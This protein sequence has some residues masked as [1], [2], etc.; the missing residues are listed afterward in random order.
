[1]AAPVAATLLPALLLVPLVVG[2]GI[3]LFCDPVTQSFP[4][5]ALYARAVGA[6]QLPLFNPYQLGGASFVGNVQA[7]VLYPPH[8]VVALARGP[9]DRSFGLLL[10]LHLAWA[11]L[12]TERL[13][14]RLGMEP[15]GAVVAALA[16]ALGG[17][18][19]GKLAL[20]PVLLTAA[21]A[22][23]VMLGVEGTLAGRSRGLGLTA[24]L[25]LLLTAGH[26]QTALAV[27][28]FATVY[29]AARLIPLRS[30]SGPAGL[31]GP[32]TVVATIL[33]LAYLAGAFTVA[34]F[35]APWFAPTRVFF[36]AVALAGVALVA[37]AR[38]GVPCEL[39]WGPLAPVARMGGALLLGSC[40]AAA[41][42]LP[43]VEHLAQSRPPR[44]PDRIERFDAIADRPALAAD[45]ILGH[46]LDAEASL[47]VGPVPALLAL[48]WL[49][50][51]GSRRR[52]PGTAYALS[53][54]VWFLIACG[55]MALRPVLLQLPLFR[56][57][58]GLTRYLVGPALSLSLLA[59]LAVGL[60]PRRARVGAAAVVLVAATI[61]P[62]AHG[63]R[64]FLVAA[65][66]ASIYPAAAPP[67]ELVRAELV[68]FFSVD[69]TP[70]LLG[71]DFR[72]ADLA[73]LLVPNL[74]TLYRLE[75]LQ[76]YDPV[77]G[78]AVTRLLAAL[79]G[80]GVAPLR[81]DYHFAL[82]RRGT[83]RLLAL[84]GVGYALVHPG[85]ADPPLG[86]ERVRALQGVDLYAL[87]GALPRAFVAPRLVIEPDPDRALELLATTLDPA[88]D[89][90]IPHTLAVAAYGSV[91]VRRPRDGR[92]VIEARD[93]TFGGL[94]VV[95]ELFD[96]AW[97]AW[98]DGRRVDPI[99]TDGV[100]VG[101]PCPSAT[102]RVELA[103]LPRGVLVGLFVA[104]LGLLT[105]CTCVAVR[106]PWP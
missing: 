84:L 70:V 18:M 4:Y 73:P 53:G 101:V 33:A 47:H 75:D 5:H 2:G 41:T 103:Y 100:L 80:A 65:T 92:L 89:A 51:R 39:A 87:R 98:V 32:V 102:R 12:G 58:G 17:Y 43:V 72:R 6:G 68:R 19:V 76:G 28:G 93:R 40:L 62:L 74:G 24:A 22:P 14:R 16:F 105:C 66:A 26:P 11:G 78:R 88:V 96:R 77:Q 79:H 7:G 31:W 60:L 104:A 21:H 48:L 64:P 83:P 3:P 46:H 25:A 59:G 34:S 99:E 30:R 29:V 9:L 35:G 44:H 10:L 56:L 95:T 13:G 37:L 1:M 69:R 91:R 94:V 36:W 45:V 67:P 23:W 71:L 52:A 82:A 42:L 81:D 63:A 38:D 90:V 57:F 8:L 54:G 55:P 85:V 15:A 20:P 97:R 106:T 61:L 50:Q 27:V 86:F 49:L